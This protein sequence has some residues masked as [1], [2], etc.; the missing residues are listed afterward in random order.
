[1]RPLRNFMLAV[2]A[3]LLLS[4]SKTEPEK[5]NVLFIA[6][7][8]LRPELG[9]YGVEAV[10]SPSIDRLAAQGIIFE[11]AY[12]NVP[13]C[14]A[15]RASLL[16]GV[17]PSYTRFV[18][19]NAWADNDLPD[20]YS[21]PQYLKESGYYTVSLGKVYHNRPDDSIAWS[22]VAWHP[23]TKGVTRDYITDESKA[24][25]AAN[26]TP[27]SEGNGPAFEAADVHD[28]MY[29]DGR[30]TLRALAKLEELKAMKQP[31]FLGVG[32]F[33][34]HLP[35]NAPK[36]YW[37]MYD[38]QK[39]AMADNP[40]VPKDAPKESIHNSPELRK[41]YSGVPEGTPLPEDYAR[42][43]KHGYYACVS[44]IDTQI[45]MII[46]KLEELGLADNTIIVL[47]GDHGWNLGEH[48]MWCKHNLYRTS[49]NAPVIIKLPGK[50]LGTKTQA[51][52]E[53]VDIYPTIAELCGLQVP[54]HCEGE[55]MVPYI[56]NPSLPG[57]DATYS[58]WHN[59]IS[60]RTQQYQYAEWLN[61]KTQEVQARMLYDHQ[62]DPD[63][64][65]NIAELP[66]NAELVQQ[67]SAQ[68]HAWWFGYL[69][70]DKE[71]GRK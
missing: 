8:D 28:T 30:T 51:H 23:Q 54:S 26:S 27:K 4:S 6:V 70:A 15:S 36:K 14:G 37:D 66:E 2:V 63:E 29:N 3:V 64:N 62:T 45:G 67:L 7:D 41:Q 40:Y 5:P 68:L 44:Y 13:V 1:M 24:I 34:P 47:W 50:Q 18:G 17:R 12:C 32:F 9:C 61:P 52:A 43:L 19:F 21:L 39:I 33:K 60:M 16:T 59:G 56:E 11:K 20:H 69:E 10:H 65:T 22:E 53:Y 46:D 25:V 57:K 55:S 48:T 49:L 38:P 35:F 58:K 31:F 71:K 42:Q